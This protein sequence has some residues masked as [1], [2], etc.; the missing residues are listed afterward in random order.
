MNPEGYRAPRRH[1][2]TIRQDAYEGTIGLKG[3]YM[4][5]GATRAQMNRAEA[6]Y[7]NYN[8]RIE[9]AENAGE[10]LDGV[11]T[12]DW[13]SNYEGDQ[14][15]AT[16]SY[17]YIDADGYTRRATYESSRTGGGGYNKESTAIANALNK[18]PEFSRLLMNAREYGVHTDYGV[19]RNE[20]KPYP[21]EYSWGV[22]VGSI[23]GV[24]RQ[25][26][27]DMSYMSETRSTRTYVLSRNTPLPSESLRSAMGNA[28]KTG[29]GIA[30]KGVAKTRQVTSNVKAK[31]KTTGKTKAPAKKPAS[32]SSRSCA[33]KT[34]TSKPAAMASNSSRSKTA[35]KTA[36]R[37]GAR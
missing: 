22:G 21:P 28:Y 19:D 20:G 12:V 32:A 25:V 35:V 1:Y 2:P 26:G 10:I 5:D 24:L 23:V 9:A 6:E 34:K 37:K 15:K 8:D 30:K 4:R 7:Q 13:R 29:K 31:A 17:R 33:S 3:D 27:I 14:A 36:G 18:S 11:I 16:L